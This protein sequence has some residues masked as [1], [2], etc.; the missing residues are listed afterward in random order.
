MS[1]YLTPEF[2]PPS[3]FGSIAVSASLSP[4][5]DRATDFK[6]YQKIVELLRNTRKFAT[7]A[8]P[9]TSGMSIS[10]SLSVV[11]VGWIEVDQ[12]DRDRVV[13]RVSYLVKILVRQ[14]DLPAAFQ[15][16]DQL[17]ALCQDLLDDSSLGGRTLPGLTRMSKG[18]IEIGLNSTDLRAILNGEFAYLVGRSEGRA[19]D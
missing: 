14:I 4:L 6:I 5:N 1:L 13:R 2:F 17:T 3:Y 15:L 19:E 18:K 9:E 10:P 7:V 8:F 12:G 16:L 11:P